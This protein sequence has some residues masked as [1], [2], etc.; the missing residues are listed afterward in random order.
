MVC[1]H[2]RR[3]GSFFKWCFVV[4]DVLLLFLFFSVHFSVSFHET[5]ECFR[6]YGIINIKRA[7]KVVFM[8]SV[9]IC[10]I[11]DWPKLCCLFI[12]ECWRCVAIARLVSVDND[13]MC[14]ASK[15]ATISNE[16][17]RRWKNWFR[18][19]Q[20]IDKKIEIG[21]CLQT[22]AQMCKSS[23]AKQRIAESLLMSRNKTNKHS[24]S[25]SIIC[26][27]VVFFLLLFFT[28]KRKLQIGDR[29]RVFINPA[30]S[31]AANSGSE[32]EHTHT[33]T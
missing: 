4:H 17:P 33:H 1:L 20:Y 7:A 31:H 13:V 16:K 18:N 25:Y 24:F 21:N 29:P 11:V 12:K 32:G 3:F 26:V 19:Q 2:F 15:I 6:W 28:S 22:L 30:H 5:V 9:R 8:A 10:A 14:W 23:K 27:C